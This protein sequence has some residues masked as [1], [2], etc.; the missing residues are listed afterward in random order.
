MEPGFEPD[1][2]AQ[3]AQVPPCPEHRLLD[4]VARELRVPEDEPGSQVQT[5]EVHADEHAEGFMIALTCPLD[6]T[7][8]V[9]GI[10]STDAADAAYMDID[11]SSGPKRSRLDRSGRRDRPTHG[12]VEHAE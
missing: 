7:P 5:R 10:P 4:R 6:E 8:L 11:G 3:P 9:H 2:V 12:H 1:R